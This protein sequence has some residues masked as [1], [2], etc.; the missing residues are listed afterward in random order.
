MEVSSVNF[1]ETASINE[2]NVSSTFIRACFSVPSSACRALKVVSRACNIPSS[3]SSRSFFSL[4]ICMRSVTISSCACA[5]SLV[6]VASRELR[7]MPSS[8]TSLGISD[9]MVAACLRCMSCVAW[10]SCPSS[11]RNDSVATLRPDRTDASPAAR[12][13]CSISSPSCVRESKCWSSAE[14][15]SLRSPRAHFSSSVS[16]STKLRWSQKSTLIFWSCCMT[17]SACSLSCASL[18]SSAANRSARSSSIP[19]CSELNF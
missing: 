5:T 3:I 9:A 6:S 15:P 16:D 18:A 19:C 17:S 10:E 7:S 4:W 14:R 11:L 12:V 13:C 1:A 2:N 8:F